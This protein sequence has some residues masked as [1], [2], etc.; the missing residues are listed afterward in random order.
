MATLTGNNFNLSKHE[1]AT[2]EFE[3]L[4]EVSFFVTVFSLPGLSIGSTE[5]A[6]P[7][8]SY[9]K[10][11]SK[12]TYEEFTVTSLIDESFLN[13]RK[14]REWILEG[15]PQSFAPERMQYDTTQVTRRSGSLILTT[16]NMNPFMTIAFKNLFPISLSSVQF[17]LQQAEPTVLSFESTFVYES[18]SIELIS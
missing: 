6:N 2:L 17:D 11:G 5:I 12:L 13:W 15:Y 3:N 14:M 4:P 1:N 7:F 18:Y 9:Q 16:N 8:L 10:E